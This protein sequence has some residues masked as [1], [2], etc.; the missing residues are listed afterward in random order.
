VV[1]KGHRGAAVI[2][3]RGETRQRRPLFDRGFGE[4]FGRRLDNLQLD[5]RGVA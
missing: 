5:D 4:T 3:D 1:E 2:D